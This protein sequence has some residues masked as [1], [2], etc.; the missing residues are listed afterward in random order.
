MRFCRVLVC[1][2]EWC[3][4]NSSSKALS[5]SV[6]C[7]IR[8]HEIL[9]MFKI[10]YLSETYLEM[11]NEIIICFRFRWFESLFILF[12]F[13]P[14]VGSKYGNTN[15]ATSWSLTKIWITVGLSY[16]AI[17]LYFIKNSFIFLRF[18]Y[19]QHLLCQIFP[20]RIVFNVLILIFS[21]V[22]NLVQL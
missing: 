13:L 17:F 21:V 11:W 16:R 2:S 15:K 18:S 3:I 20:R 5:A 4:L 14:V 19:E 9:K 10:Q 6:E 12:L 8:N 1:F 7:K 22:Y